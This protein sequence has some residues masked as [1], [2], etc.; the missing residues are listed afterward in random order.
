MTT[1]YIG[2][3]LFLVLNIVGGLVRLVRGPTAADRMLSVQLFGTAGVAALLL[4]AEAAAEPAFRD[5]ALVFALLAA[6]ATIVFVKRVW[7]PETI[8]PGDQA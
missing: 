6:L 7:T 4:L 3:S 5:V 1:F 8:Q 2:V